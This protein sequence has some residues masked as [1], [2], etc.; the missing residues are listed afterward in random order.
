MSFL[1]LLPTLVV[2]AVVAAAMGYAWARR[3]ATSSDPAG[4]QAWSDLLAQSERTERELRREIQEAARYARQEQ[5]ESLALF[6]RNLNEQFS[7]QQKALTETLQRRL[8]EIRR[9][10]DEQLQTQL[11]AKLTQS[12]KQVADGLQQVQQGLGQMQVMAQDVG[13]L[14]R[15]LS[16][17]KTRGIFGE[18]QLHALLEQVLTPEQFARQAAIIPGKSVNVDFAVRLPGR[19]DETPVWLPIDAKFPREDFERLL[20]AQAQSDVAGVEAA[21]KALENQIWSEAKSIA[22]KYISVPHTTDFAILFLPSESLFAEA[23]RRPG[24]MDGLQRKHRVTLAGPTTML[25]LLNSLQMGFRTL[26]LERQ[27]SEVWQVLGAVKTEFERYGKWVDKVRDQVHQAA[28]T[29]D[30][31]ETRSRQMRRALNRVHALPAEQ[32]QDLLPPESEG[33]GA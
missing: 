6:Q 13:N 7:L 16:N 15:V 2:V 5:Q 14:Q 19:G 18:I 12:F 26:A 28:N 32:A 4:A 11:E 9:T 10:V 8:E 23:L 22:D 30:Q 3:D 21:A 1:D 17:V 20:D 31:A 24:L 29:L 33:E 25:A 27:A